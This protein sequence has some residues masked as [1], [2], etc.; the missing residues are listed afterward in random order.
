MQAIR[1]LKTGIEILETQSLIVDRRETGDTE[2]LLDIKKGKYTYDQV[3][4]MA[5]NL[6][7]K[8]DEAAENSTLPKQVDAEVVNQLCIEL[9]SQQGF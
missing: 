8:L 3:M 7:Q 2:E 9:V 6:Y 5:K 1:L 4:E